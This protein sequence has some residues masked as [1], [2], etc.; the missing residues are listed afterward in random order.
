[1]LKKLL[2]DREQVAAEA[3]GAEG[4]VQNELAEELR[5]LDRQIEQMRGEI[6]L[7]GSAIIRVRITASTAGPISPAQQQRRRDRP[8]I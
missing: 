8:G 6:E 2:S 7:L 4:I 3:Q 1:M 5:D